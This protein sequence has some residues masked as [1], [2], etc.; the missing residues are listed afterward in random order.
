VRGWLPHGAIGRRGARGVEY[1]RGGADDLP[2]S[3]VL[4]GEVVDPATGLYPAQNGGL[5]G[6]RCDPYQVRDNPAD[7]KYRVDASLR[8]PPGMTIERLASKRTLLAELGPSTVNLGGGA[9]G[10]FLRESPQ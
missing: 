5:L 8:M 10:R 9:G 7:P 3:V 4:P 1:A 6:A 2:A